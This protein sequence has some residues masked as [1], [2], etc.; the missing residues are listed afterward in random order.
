MPPL[1]LTSDALLL[2]CAVECPL[3][4]GPLKEALALTPV[5]LAGRANQLDYKDWQVPLG[6]KFR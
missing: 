2:C 3:S 5:F 6:R 4:Q 1:A